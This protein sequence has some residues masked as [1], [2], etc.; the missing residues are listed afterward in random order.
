MN[1]DPN[2]TVMLP[3]KIQRDRGIVNDAHSF[4]KGHKF[5]YIGR[6]DDPLDTMR[7]ELPDGWT[8]A[9]TVINGKTVIKYFNA[10]NDVAFQVHSGTAPF[11]EPIIPPE[12]TRQRTNN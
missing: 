7:W 4:L 3:L 5:C 10:Y 11:I 6:H 1:I 8:Y 12:R 2:R 9:E